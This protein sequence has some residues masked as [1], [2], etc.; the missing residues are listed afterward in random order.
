MSNLRVNELLFM[1]FYV[2]EEMNTN[3][4]FIQQKLS[5]YG[6]LEYLRGMDE[7]PLLAAIHPQECNSNAGP[8]PI[9][10]KVE[11]I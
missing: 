4:L 5:I 11:R 6:D 3:C 8:L 2:Y 1:N 7:K 10:V 9:K